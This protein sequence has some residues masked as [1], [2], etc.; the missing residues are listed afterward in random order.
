MNRILPRLIMW[1]IPCLVL[2]S[3]VLADTTWAVTRYVA[4]TGNDANSCAASA[5]ITTPKHTFASAVACMAPGDIL[6]VRAGI[7][8]E[9]LRIDGKSGTAG[10]PI[11]YAGY[12]GERPCLT[13]KT[14]QGQVGIYGPYRNLSNY[15]VIRNFLLDGTCDGSPVSSLVADSGWSI[16]TSTTNG[17]NEVPAPH[18]VLIDDVEVTHW[19]GNGLF[20]AQGA[21]NITVQNSKFHDMITVYSGSSCT[22]AG[23][24][25]QGRFY[26]FYIHDTVNVVLQGNE[27]YNNPGGGMQ[28]YPGPNTGTIIRN[29]NIH[30]NNMCSNAVFGGVVIQ[31][32]AGAQITNGVQFYNNLVCNN[33][34]DARSGNSFGVQLG[35]GAINSKVWNN[36]VYGNKNFGI[37][38]IDASVTNSI[39]QNN[40]AYSNNGGGTQ[41]LN[42][43]AG[44]SFSTNLC[45]A[46][47]GAVGC[48]AGN[49]LFVNA[50]GLDFHI[51]AG[52]PTINTGTTIASVTSDY[53]GSARPQ[54]G[55]YDIGAYEFTGVTSPPAAPSGVRMN[56]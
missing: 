8:T 19:R 3:A 16:G 51:Q 53:T 18:D 42:A 22:D 39:V 14:G 45:N 9:Q 52:S 30:N 33:G 35:F 56:Y 36:T 47:N 34:S 44:S 25:S 10:A 4:L 5:T 1:L 48:T 50:A 49:P 31:S 2:G 20:I 24:G 26:G 11:T 28:V 43:G 27:V 15:I 7:W 12:P 55:A 6:Y 17:V 29:N 46:T 41:I 37:D 21:T 23:A 13:N 38:I 40:I 32:G 54:G